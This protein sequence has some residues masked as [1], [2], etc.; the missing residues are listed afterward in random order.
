MHLN[1]FNFEI[2]LINVFL[3]FK[4]KK[5]YKKKLN[6]M[7]DQNVKSENAMKQSFKLNVEMFK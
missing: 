1:T 2:T 7:G 6:A 4:L 3:K 5:K